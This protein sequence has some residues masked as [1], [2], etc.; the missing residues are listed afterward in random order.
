[1]FPGCVNVGSSVLLLA[2]LL[3]TLLSGCAVTVAN[4]QDPASVYSAIDAKVGKVFPADVRDAKIDQSHFGEPVDIGTISVERFSR[5]FDDLFR[6]T[7]ELRE[8]SLVQDS[9]AFDAIITLERVIGSFKHCASPGS[10]DYASVFY[11]VCLYEPEAD[12]IGCWQTHQSRTDKHNH[13][14]C[15]WVTANCVGSLLDDAV[16]IAIADILVQVKSDASVQA[17]ADRVGQNSNSEEAIQAALASE[18]KGSN[19]QDD[20][21]C[22][23]L[24]WWE[25]DTDDT[26]DEFASD[27]E[28]CLAR[29]LEKRLPGR[30][31]YRREQIRELLY[32]LIEP[33]TIPRTEDEFAE[34]LM[35]TQ[36]HLR[37][38]REGIR[39]VV[40]FNGGTT[41]GEEKGIGACGYNGC[42]GFGWWGKETFLSAKLWDI[43]EV[44]EAEKIDAGDRG[45][46]VIP[47]FILPIP[48]PAATQADACREL[49]SRIAES[50]SSGH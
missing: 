11:R 34:I 26:D 18:P 23:A 46:T 35:R 50:I 27:I 6:E 45:T 49:A 32:P 38:E 12:Y 39:Y 13:L 21:T 36:V 41:I 10:T 22:I 5:A 9:S 48:I 30:T 17:W 28:S 25:G 37:L 31:V 2:L 42:L 43:K 4:T 8:S 3:D 19:C 7:E 40:A 44:G 14:I 15:P 33:S 20:S 47:I 1:M 24:V 16:R 29:G